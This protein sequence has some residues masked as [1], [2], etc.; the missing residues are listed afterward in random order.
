MKKTLTLLLAF[1]MAI[2]AMAQG[3]GKGHDKDKNDKHSDGKSNHH[4]G[5]DDN[6]NNGIYRE[7]KDD[8]KV[9]H[10]KKNKNYSYTKNLPSKVRA[11]FSRDFPN[12]TNVTWTKSNGNWTAT[13]NRS[14]LGRTTATYHANGQRIG[15]TAQTPPVRRRI[16]G[17]PIPPASN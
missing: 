4:D 3:K 2:A 8:D 17:N 6:N 10:Q 9:D 14:I 15:G 16:L 12:A 1:S 13:F 11:A 5:N 7:R